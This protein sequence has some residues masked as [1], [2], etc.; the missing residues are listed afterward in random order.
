MDSNR[1]VCSVAALSETCLTLWLFLRKVLG[2][3]FINTEHQLHYVTIKYNEHCADVSSFMA[4]DDRE[5]G[6]NTTHSANTNINNPVLH[7]LLLLFQIFTDLNKIH[8]RQW[9]YRY[10][11]DD[12]K[13]DAGQTIGQKN[14]NEKN[15]RMTWETKTYLSE[16]TNDQIHSGGVK[17]CRKWANNRPISLPLA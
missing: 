13:N 2:F 3:K 12:D 6:S 15:N 9:T 5:I 11:D 7:L 8:C 10:D 16:F 1:L 17:Y 4:C 14:K